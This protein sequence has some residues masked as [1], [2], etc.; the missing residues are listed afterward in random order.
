MYLLLAPATSEHP[1][2]HGEQHKARRLRTQDNTALNA[3]EGGSALCLGMPECARGSELGQ[4]VPTIL[5]H[6]GSFSLHL[7]ASPAG[8]SYCSGT[9]SSTEVG[10]PRFRHPCLVCKLLLPPSVCELL[11]WLPD[12]SRH[13]RSL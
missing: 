12:N 2:P 7:A 4:A 1:G 9:T 13:C 10:G 8:T 5:L 6:R 3:G 11:P